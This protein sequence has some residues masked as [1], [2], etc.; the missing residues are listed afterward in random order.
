VSLTYRPRVTF[1]TKV[2]ET[3]KRLL[4]EGAEKVDLAVLFQHGFLTNM[5][6]LYCCLRILKQLG[7]V[8]EDGT[9]NKPLAEAFIKQQ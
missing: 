8:Q 4:K 3:V 2:K 7:I 1:Q 5:S 6:E 9:L